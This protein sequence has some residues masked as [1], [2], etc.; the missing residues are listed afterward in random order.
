MLYEIFNKPELKVAVRA[1]LILAFAIA[2][3]Y[4]IRTI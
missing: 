2:I 1:I 3:F 4:N